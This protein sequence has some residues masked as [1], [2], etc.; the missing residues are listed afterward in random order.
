MLTFI[1]SKWVYYTIYKE[2]IKSADQTAQ[3]GLCAFDV[4]MHQCQIFLRCQE[5]D[6]IFVHST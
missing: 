2:N 6:I 3:S 5:N 1:G 4:L